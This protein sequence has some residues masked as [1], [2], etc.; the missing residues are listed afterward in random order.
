MP[1]ERT[2]DESKRLICAR[3][4]IACRDCHMNPVETALSIAR[5]LK[6]PE[7]LE[8]EVERLR[9][10]AGTVAKTERAVV[11]NHEFVGGNAVITA[12][13]MPEKTARRHADIA[14]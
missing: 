2:Y 12:A 11:H 14:R 6:R 10:R 13:L 7:D 5:M 4:D 9:G 8:D 3:H 1:I